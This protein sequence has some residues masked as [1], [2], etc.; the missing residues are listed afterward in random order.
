[1]VWFDLALL[2]LATNAAVEYWLRGEIFHER[3]AALENSSWKE[4]SQCG[5]CLS[6][7]V[8]LTLLIVSFSPLRFLL[9]ALAVARLAN[10]LRDL[11]PARTKFENLTRP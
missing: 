4:F 11:W 6:P 1:M 3:R 2:A 5:L 9:Y 8:A 7:W 10:L